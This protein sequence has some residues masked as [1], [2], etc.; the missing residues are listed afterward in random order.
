MTELDILALPF[1]YIYSLKEFYDWSSRRHFYLNHLQINGECLYKEEKIAR[2]SILNRQNNWVSR[3]APLS[4]Y[5]IRQVIKNK[6]TQQW[7]NLRETRKE[8]ESPCGK[9]GNEKGI[10]SENQNCPHLFSVF[11]SVLR[12]W[13]RFFFFLVLLIFLI[14]RI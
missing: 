5:E 6:Y 8:R 2:V 4:S 10:A 11:R 3:L 9:G 13:S 12:G 7:R 14:L 1:K